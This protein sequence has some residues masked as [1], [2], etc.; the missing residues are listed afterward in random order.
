MDLLAPLDPMETLE[1]MVSEEETVPPDPLGRMDEFSSPMILSDQLDL[2]VPM[3]ILVLLDQ[4]D[5]LELLVC[6][7]FLE[8]L[9]PPALLDLPALLDQLEVMEAEVWKE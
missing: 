4:T 7:N 2:L 5:S 1:L 9:A 8:V 6:V 3:E